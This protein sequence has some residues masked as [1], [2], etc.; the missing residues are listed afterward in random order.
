MFCVSVYPCR[1]T[2][3]LT[4]LFTIKIDVS[5][6]TAML[7]LSAED[8]IKD[9]TDSLAS[10][11]AFIWRED[12]DWEGHGGQQ[13]PHQSKPHATWK[14][15]ADEIVNEQYQNDDSVLNQLFEY[16]S[17]LLDETTSSIENNDLFKKSIQ[18][19][20]SNEMKRS[21]DMTSWPCPSFWEGVDT[22]TVSKADGDD[23]NQQ[24]RILQHISSEMIPNCRDNDPFVRCTVNKDR[25]EVRRDA[26]CK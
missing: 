2:F 22:T 7:T 13:H 8:V 9:P 16:T 15:E 11:L 17:L 10:I 6:H 21:S 23:N 1:S 14:L 4:Y 20:F 18:G 5:A 19:A 3:G 12:W 25:C 26:K 24:K